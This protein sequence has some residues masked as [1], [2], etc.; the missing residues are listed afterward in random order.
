MNINRALAG[1][2]LS[3]VFLLVFLY[4]MSEMQGFFENALQNVQGQA[5]ILQAAENL[6]SV[7]NQN[8]PL[9]ELNINA[10]A[11]ISVETNLSDINKTVF[12]KSSSEKLQIASL[13]KLMTALIVVEN[14]DLSQKIKI[15]DQA[16]NQTVDP[17]PLKAGETF[18]AKDLLQAMLIGSDNTASYAL[19][20]AVGKEKFIDLMNARAGE[21]G[22]SDTIFLNPTGIGLENFSTA[23]DMS[24]LAAYLLKEQ[25]SIFK[26]T[27]TPEFNINT[28]DGKI[29]HEIINTNELLGDSSGLAKRIVG[30]KT[31]DTR[32]AGQC[33]ILA[34]KSLDDQDYLIT[35]VLNSRDRFGEMKKII[36]WIDENY[37]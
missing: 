22:L 19:Y 21:L 27:T 10:S 30:G 16:A 37:Y 5:D 29:N 31:G 33:L 17:E 18:Y 2:L 6:N 9:P 32:T 3:F 15:S 20:E 24:K 12:E 25:P 13:T 36:N 4:A 1:F 28:V 8:L 11:A 35:V 23:H 14:L 7:N 34:V 26:I